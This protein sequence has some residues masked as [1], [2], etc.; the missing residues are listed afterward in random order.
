MPILKLS[1]LQLQRLK[2]VLVWLY[3][4]LAII[5][6]LQQYFRGEKDFG[7][8]IY[9]HYNNYLIF[10]TGAHR[11]LQG[12]NPFIGD[13]TLHFD[14]LK[15]SPPFC[16]WMNLIAWMPNLAGIITW[17]LLNGIVLA[18]GLWYIPLK[19]EKLRVGLLALCAIE[20]LTSFQN[21]QSNALI[22]GCMLL[23]F[24][25]AERKLWIWAPFFIVFAATVKIFALAGFLGFLFYKGRWQ[26]IL[27]SAIWFLFFGLSP[28][29][30]TGFSGFIQVYQ[31]WFDAILTDYSHSLGMS[32]MSMFK[33]FGLDINKT[34]FQIAALLLLMIGATYF[35]LWDN[36]TYRLNYLSSILIFLVAFNQRAESPTFIISAV[37]AFM[38]LLNREMDIKNIALIVFVFYITTLSATDLFPRSWRN[39]FINPHSLKVLPVFMVWL[40]LQWDLLMQVLD[41]KV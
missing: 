19:N 7:G 36:Y 24:V 16:L 25:C 1:D 2:V 20:A 15:Y 32:V 41:K 34:W 9:T 18:I 33:S 22:V 31:W 27:W 29:L 26:L 8:E 17:N 5:A 10:K 13:T 30:V 11:L 40:V 4:I 39:D 21:L 12:L 3:P 37:G 6:G 23:A 35:K 14:T 38:Y 28:M